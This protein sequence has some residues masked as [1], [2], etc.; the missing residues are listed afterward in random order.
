[1][2]RRL[3]RRSSLLAGAAFPLSIAARVIHAIH[4]FVITVLG[5]SEPAP[6]PVH[7]KELGADR[8]HARPAPVLR[9][10]GATVRPESTFDAPVTFRQPPRQRSTVRRPLIVRATRRRHIGERPAQ[11]PGAFQLA[12]ALFRC[13]LLRCWLRLLI[14]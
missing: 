9:Q 13:R 12:F 7:I 5:D 2:R 11:A 4:S 14:L 10:E 6:A 1:M 3:R 8:G